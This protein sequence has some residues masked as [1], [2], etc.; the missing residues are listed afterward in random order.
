MPALAD[1]FAVR[2]HTGSVGKLE[3][4]QTPVARR[5][6]IEMKGFVRFANAL[7]RHPR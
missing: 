6:W 1:A 2:A 4:N 3:M 7:R 5:H